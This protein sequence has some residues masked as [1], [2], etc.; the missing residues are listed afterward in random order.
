MRESYA[1]QYRSLWQN[2][3]WWQSRQEFVYY[4]VRRVARGHPCRCIL[5][6]GCGDGL[7][8][9]RLLE[10]GDTY[11]IEPDENLLNE[12][13]PFRDRID[14]T[15][16][17]PDYATNR[18]FDLVLMLDVLEHINDDRGALARIWSLLNSGGYLILT[19]PALQFLWSLHDVAN[20][21]CRRYTRHSLKRLLT[22]Q[23]FEIVRLGYYFGWTVGP[24]LLRRV[25]AASRR[26]SEGND[27]SYR[28]HIP[29]RV[30]N[31]ALYWLTLGEQRASRRLGLPIGSSL[32]AVVRK[33]AE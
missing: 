10:I 29:P 18:S 2:H 25:F 6:V 16:F 30:I 3:W 26:E 23:N 11:G 13:S 20:C 9:E 15:T 1:Q 24:M 28:V 17:G 27:D 14:V 7:F 5:D 33:S 21:H 32:F 31:S 8:F 22:G 19:V 12:D 4:W